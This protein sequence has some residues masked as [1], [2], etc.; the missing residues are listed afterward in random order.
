MA[1]LGELR[2]EELIPILESAITNGE[3]PKEIRDVAL[4]VLQSSYPEHVEKN[5]LPIAA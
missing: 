5:G 2:Q 3:Y 4:E 1:I